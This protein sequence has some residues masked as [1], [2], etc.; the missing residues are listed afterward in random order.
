MSTD[1]TEMGM[2]QNKERPRLPRTTGILV[3]D[4]MNM[5][6]FGLGRAINLARQAL[7]E[8]LE[9]R[10]RL[11]ELGQVTLTCGEEEMIRSLA[12]SSLSGEIAPI[13]A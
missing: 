5:F 12:Q 10:I 1:L 3:D 11:Y 7:P 8:D 4:D 6:P 13:A 9:S 2:E